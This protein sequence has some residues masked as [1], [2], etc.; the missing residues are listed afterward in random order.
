MMLTFFVNFHQGGKYSAQ[1]A[2]HQRELRREKIFIDQKSLSV[3][4][5]QTNYLNLD[6]SSSFE[7][8]VKKQKLFRQIALF[9]EV[10]INLQK[11]VSKGLDRKRKNL[12]RLVIRTTDE[13]NGHLGNVLDVDIK[14]TYLQNIQSH[15][16]ILKNGKRKYVL[17]KKINRVCDNGIN[18]S[19]KNI[20]ASMA[21][22]YGN[23]ECPG[24]NFGDRS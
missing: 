10:L 24:R 6:S 3:S 4:S 9:V 16:K 12:V 18:N 21:R 23:D 2:R 19:D 20:Y 8:K 7:G 15:Q 13:Q 1:I 5:L 17:I 14:I 22:I 11:N